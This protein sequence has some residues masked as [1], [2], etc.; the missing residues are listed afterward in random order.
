MNIR[1]YMPLLSFFLLF[2]CQ[3]SER[4]EKLKKHAINV[5]K[6][7]EEVIDYHTMN[8]HFAANGMER[9]KD[10]KKALDFYRKN[11][12]YL[13]DYTHNEPDSLI[14]WRLTQTDEARF[15]D[16]APSLDSSLIFS[17]DTL[18]RKT[19]L[20]VNL[21]NYIRHINSSF[22]F[23]AV[24]YGSTPVV[25]S[26]DSNIINLYGIPPVGSELEIFLKYKN[27]SFPSYIDTTDLWATLKIHHPQ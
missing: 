23:C 1:F 19:E 12:Y 9:L 6:S 27:N 2:S 18:M 20:L 15:Q 16:F 25:D 8:F 5:N 17:N 13:I 26:R 11:T 10:H 21:N 14:Y 3:D 4:E 7:L 24:I 22:S